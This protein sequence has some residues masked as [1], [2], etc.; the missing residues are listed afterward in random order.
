MDK[1]P[2]VGVFNISDVMLDFSEKN[3]LAQLCKNTLPDVYPYQM[4]MDITRYCSNWNANNKRLKD[5]ALCCCPYKSSDFTP[6]HDLIS[7]LS[8]F[9]KNGGHSFFVTGG[10]EPGEYPEWKE[11][12]AFLSDSSL[13]LTLNTNGA[14]IKI[15]KEAE[16]EVLYRCFSQNKNTTAISISVHDET[17]YQAIRWLYELREK[18]NLNLFIRTSYLVHPDTTENEI[19]SFINMCRSSGADLI[20]IKPLY[21][22]VNGRRK[23]INNNNVFDMMNNKTY[24]KQAGISI[25]NIPKFARLSNKFANN[26]EKYETEMKKTLCFSPLISLFLN[27]DR[28]WGMCCDTKEARMGSI[29]P[30]IFGNGMFS[31]Y[32]YYKMALRGIVKLDTSRCIIG[33]STMEINNMLAGSEKYKTFIIF[34]LTI[35]E[36]YLDNTISDT[37]I[38]CEINKIIEK[39]KTKNN[40]YGL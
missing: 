11:L 37:E 15:M 24:I 19:H 5:C 2:A 29:Q 3:I 4:Q 36:K 16:P 14:F 33:C 12:L 28:D 10:G 26:Y 32:S 25:Q 30:E 6:L 9:E 17:A 40:C 34:L 38:E 18:F 22:V 23:Y 31:L 21:R 39:K 35:R 27:T 8:E 13:E 1:I 7:L 20:T